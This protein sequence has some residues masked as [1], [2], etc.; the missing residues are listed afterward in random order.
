MVLVL[1]GWCELTRR[2]GIQCVTVMNLPLDPVVL[3]VCCGVLG[4]GLVMYRSG[5]GDGVTLCDGKVVVC[6]ANETAC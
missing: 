3:R 2:R 4:C 6:F 5:D 1:Q